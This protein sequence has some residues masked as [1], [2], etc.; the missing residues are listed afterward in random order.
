M[1]KQYAR[2]LFIFRRDLR[3]ND[4][5]GLLAALEQTEEVVPCFI[6]D[7]RQVDDN[8]YKSENALRFM[9]ES[10]NDLADQLKHKHG[11]LY[12]FYGK[13]EDV[14][15]K[16]CTQ[17][18]LDAVFINQDYT[19]FSIKRDHALERVCKSQDVA[20]QAHADVLLHAP[21]KSLKKDGKP[22]TIFTPFYK[23]MSMIKVEEPR[24]N[25]F[26]NYFTGTIAT[27]FHNI[28]DKVSIKTNKLA[29]VQGGRKACLKI[30]RALDDFKDY[31]KKRD[32]PALATTHL[33]AHLK[34]GTCSVRE[35][36]YAIADTLGRKSVLL[37]QLY[38][39]DFFTTIVFY[40][41]HVFGHAFREKYNHL[42]WSKSKKN[43][44]AWC[45][46]MTGFPLVD[47]GMR[48]LNETGFMHNRVRMVVAS[49]L[50]K[51]LHLDW[52]LGE[53]YFAQKLVD[54]DPAVNNGN[55]QWAAST[56]CDA[57]PYFRIFNPWLQQK[58][59][60]PQAEYIKQWIPELKNLTPKQIHSWY[61]NEKRPDSD[62]PAPLVDHSDMAAQAKKMF[63][64]AL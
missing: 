45:N 29:A 8:E 14:V 34:F 59:Y 61:N 13:S 54:C 26:K 24:S 46:G 63:K 17:L 47:A 4:N 39:R 31:A 40:F 38:W 42:A 1:T 19:P 56:G 37:K 20:F 55:W 28:E 50:V 9:I 52:R 21:E 3:L 60:D 10:L 18:K 57:Q 36:F 58:K 64:A 41:P 15:K 35:V 7:P 53:K 51:D 48:E 16:L 11:R 44:E 5:T 33:S 22:Y 30:L 23:R 27:S 25:A 12:L 49:F 62:Y 43:F 32:I 2:A 6:F